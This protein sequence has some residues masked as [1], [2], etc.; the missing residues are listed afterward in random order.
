MS[1]KAFHVFFIVISF[2]VSTYFGGWCFSQYSSTGSP[3]MLV[4]AFGSFVVASTLSLYLLWFLKKY[5]K[6]GFLAL[7]GWLLM[8]PET[9]L[10][11]S[12][13]LGDPNSPMVKSVN[14]GVWFLLAVISTVLVGFG[15]LFLF[16]R[17]RAIQ[18]QF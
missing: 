18:T 8:R 3:W 14:A 11:C 10:A 15:S 7:L 17:K 13:C 5:K 4:A 9:S 12:V 16:W 2:L 6:I 1:L